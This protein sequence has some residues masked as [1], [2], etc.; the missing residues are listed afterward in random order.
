MSARNPATRTTLGVALVTGAALL[1]SACGSSGS[2][3][4]AATTAS[5]NGKVA[6][7]IK[8]LDNPFFQSME[9]GLTDQAK[10]MHAQ[11]LPQMQAQARELN[12]AKVLAMV[13]GG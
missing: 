12:A 13:R 3:G 8:G 10:G 9:Q 11:Y 7:V 1:A 5:G 6:A 2:S 4:A